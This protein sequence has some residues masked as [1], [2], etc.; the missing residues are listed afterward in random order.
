[1]HRLAWLALLAACGTQSGLPRPDHCDQTVLGACVVSE[2]RPA[3]PV[4][5]E[6]QVRAA[7]AYWNAPETTLSGWAIVFKAGAVGCPTALGTGCTSWKDDVIDLQTLDPDCLEATQLVH[8]IGH[9][10]HH[11]PGHTG[12]WWSWPREQDAT[13]DI[14]HHP[15][16]SPGCAVTRYYVIRP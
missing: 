14:V 12:P 3:D 15:G 9:V 1:M 16:A 8:E 7:L 6:R 13:W 11:D 2:T 5:L 4:Q 10:L